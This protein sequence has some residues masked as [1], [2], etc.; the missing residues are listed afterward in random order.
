[1]V[2]KAITE[3]ELTLHVK[4]SIENMTDDERQQ[5]VRI[6]IPVQRLMCRRD[7]FTGDEPMF[8]VARSGNLFIIFD[9]AED[10]F[11]I[12]ISSNEQETLRHWVLAGELKHALQA[13]TSGDFG[14]CV[15]AP[16][17]PSAF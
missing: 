9:D 17:S 13:L 7:D 15:V 6:R 11:G 5:F 2:W 3:A 8:A 16:D 1:M 4:T 10:D 12:A 14:A